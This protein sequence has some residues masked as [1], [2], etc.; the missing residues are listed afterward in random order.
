MSEAQEDDRDLDEQE[1][2][3]IHSATERHINKL[4][5]TWGKTRIE[6]MEHL[7]AFIENDPDGLILLSRPAAF[8]IG[9]AA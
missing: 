2:D 6:V 4:A 9:R 1:I 5:A 7:V 8:I 3:E